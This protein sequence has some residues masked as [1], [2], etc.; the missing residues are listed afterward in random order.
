MICMGCMNTLQEG[1]AK[2]KHCGYP[3]V[4]INPAE[5]LP[6]RTVL[7]ERYLVGRVLE[8][9]GDSAVY[10]GLDQNDN[11]RVTIREFFPPELAKRAENAAV[12]AAEGK[13][14]VFASCRVKFLNLA[15]A[16]ARLREVLVVVPAYDIFEENGTAYSIS[17]YCEGISLEK[18]V[19]KRGGRLPVEEVRR[20]FLPLI[21]A[22]NTIHST[23]V[24]HLALSPKNILVDCEGHLN[25]KNFA[26]NEVRT[27]SGIGRASRVA[28]CAAPE[29]YDSGATCT[30]A[31]DVYGLAASM[32][33]A[34]TGRLPA[35]A[36]QRLKRGGDELMMP[37]EVADSLPPYIHESLYRALRLHPERRTRTVQQLLDELSATQAVASL[38]QPEEP[39]Q[40]RKKKRRFPFV[41]LFFLLAI[42]GLV[43]LVWY[44]LNELGMWTQTKDTIF[45]LFGGSEETTVSTTVPTTIMTTEPVETEPSVTLYTVKNVLGKTLREAQNDTYDGSMRVV[46]AGYLYDS[47]VPNGQIISQSPSVGDQAK[48]GTV[49][50]VI[51]S[52]GKQPTMP[53]VVGLPGEEVKAMLEDLG[54]VVVISERYGPEVET[55][56]I[57]KSSPAAGARLDVGEEITLLVNNHVADT[58]SDE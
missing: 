58:A 19:E 37:A 22:M 39:P 54:Y 1:E 31:A 4:G 14:T 36:P 16:V 53:D 2:C 28:G 3:A 25:L 49:I 21:S 8:I 33:F 42:I 13:D 20:M 51:I 12:V 47:T 43:V 50:E 52:M 24:L 55:G 23:G 27:A 5:Y 7:N 41:A 57:Y 11:S 6:V 46:L 40:M 10:I 15:R 38:R 35:E 18:Y 29:Q 32:F 34:L 17:E 9:G 26:I 45:G 44:V 48:A 30:G 56:A